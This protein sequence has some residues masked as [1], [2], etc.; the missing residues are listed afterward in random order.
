MAPSVGIFKRTSPGNQELLLSSTGSQAAAVTAPAG[1]DTTNRLAA[2]LRLPLP[3]PQ[4]CESAAPCPPSLH[5]PGTPRLQPPGALRVV[6]AVL[7]RLHPRLYG[8]QMCGTQMCSAPPSS[9]GQPGDA[10]DPAERPGNAPCS[11]QP[12][13]PVPGFAAG[14]ALSSRPRGQPLPSAPLTAARFLQAQPR[15]MGPSSPALP[16]LPG[17]GR[18]RSP[19]PRRGSPR[20]IRAL[21]HDNL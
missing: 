7:G 1:Q 8:T 6:A 19:R 14:W 9:A 20:P 18:T 3:L 4:P 21:P 11:P 5:C 10:Q 16:S 17:G 15:R 12:V 13:H 2:R